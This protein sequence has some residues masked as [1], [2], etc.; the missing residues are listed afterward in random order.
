MQQSRSRK[1]GE[2]AAAYM[3]ELHHLT[4]HCN[5]GDTL[6][7][8]LRDRLSVWGLNNAGIQRK[9]FLSV[10]SYGKGRLRESMHLRIT[11]HQGRVVTLSPAQWYNSVQLWLPFCA[12]LV[13][14]QCSDS[15]NR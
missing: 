9:Q 1:E 15:V 14:C 6:D 3:A 2:S 5:C 11:R 7:R 10:R 13:S 12:L 8:M 4:E